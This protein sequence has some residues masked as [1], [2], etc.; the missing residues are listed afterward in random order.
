M[1]TCL[2]AETDADGGDAQFDFI[3]AAGKQHDSQGSHHKRLPW[4]DYAA[5]R[6][7]A[8]Q[9]LLRGCTRA[10]HYRILGFPA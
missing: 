10:A 9:T 1:L 6:F 5:L 2:Q 7:P 3:D 8:L 4:G